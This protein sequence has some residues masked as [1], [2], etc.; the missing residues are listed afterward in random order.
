MQAFF[1][2]QAI[3]LKQTKELN[4]PARQVLQVVTTCETIVITLYTGEPDSLV[5][6]EEI[7]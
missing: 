6:K 1:N 5:F 4:T 3:I 7:Q 2:T